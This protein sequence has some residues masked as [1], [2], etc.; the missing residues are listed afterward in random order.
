MCGNYILPLDSDERV[1]EFRIPGIKQ[2]LH[3]DNKCKALLLAIG[4][5]WKQL[6]AG[7]L[8][9]VFEDQEKGW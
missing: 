8:R 1:H 2:T 9:K 5:D 3:C 6:P 4:S 7:P